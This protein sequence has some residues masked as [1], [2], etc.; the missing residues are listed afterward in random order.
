MF[1]Y[2]SFAHQ[3]YDLF[4]ESL[5]IVLSPQIHKALYSV[6]KKYLRSLCSV[7]ES[8]IL[9]SVIVETFKTTSGSFSLLFNIR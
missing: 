2:K 9:I 1:K 8:F 6:F 3:N 5:F 4:S 7:V